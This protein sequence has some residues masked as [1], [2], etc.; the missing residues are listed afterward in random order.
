MNTTS[1]DGKITWAEGLSLLNNRCILKRA[2]NVHKHSN[3][4]TVNES[5]I[6][7]GPISQK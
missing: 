4:N 5:Q 6:L 3:P 1:R 7:S 2:S